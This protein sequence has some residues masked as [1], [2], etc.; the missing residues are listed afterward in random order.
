MQQ[1]TLSGESVDVIVKKLDEL[2]KQHKE[3]QEEV[4]GELKEQNQLLQRLLAL[5]LDSSAAANRGNFS[6]EPE[7]PHT[8]TTAKPDRWCSHPEDPSK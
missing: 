4:I 1:F 8:A 5:Q 3:Q 6:S 2:E 7:P